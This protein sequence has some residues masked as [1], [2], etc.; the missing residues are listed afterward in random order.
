MSR[1][2]VGFRTRLVLLFVLLAIVPIVLLTVLY[3]RY[4]TDV[5]EFWQNPGI[6]R[7]LENS[8]AVARESL[9]HYRQEAEAAGEFTLVLLDPRADA[10]E[11]SRFLHANRTEVDVD[12]IMGNAVLWALA[13]RRPRTPEGLVGIEGLGPWKRQAYGEAILRVLED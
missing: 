6:E 13:E 7:S 2:R 12:V 11:T 9:E 10:E 8:L 3:L 5:I 4:L 1:T